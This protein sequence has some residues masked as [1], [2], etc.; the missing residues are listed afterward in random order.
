MASETITIT[1]QDDGSYTAK[2]DIEPGS[3]I[4][5]ACAALA[6]AVTPRILHAE[7]TKAAQHEAKA[8]KKDEGK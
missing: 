8:A 3:D 6:A 4:D 1:V 7:A 2:P 5:R